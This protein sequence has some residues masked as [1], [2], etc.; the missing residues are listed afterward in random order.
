MEALLNILL[1]L[2][3][4]Y[5]PEIYQD[6][7]AAFKKSG[8]TVAQVDEIFSALKPYDQLGINPNAPTVPE[9]TTPVP[10]TPPLPSAPNPA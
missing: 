6:I 7:L 5:G 1:P 9:N 10:G 2:A 8:Y 3:V 4:K